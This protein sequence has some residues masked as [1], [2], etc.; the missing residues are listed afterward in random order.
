MTVGNSQIGNSQIGNSQIGHSHVGGTMGASA[1]VPA[2]ATLAADA[3]AARRSG[4]LFHPLVDFFC[5]GGGSLLAL[6]VLALFVPVREAQVTVAVWALAATHAINHP[7]FAHSYQLFYAG[8][9]RKA[10][11]DAFPPGLRRRYLFA[12]VAVP[13]LLAA[14]LAGTVLAGDKRMLGWAGNAMVFFVGWHYAKQGYGMAMLDAVLKRRF[15]AAGEKR[16]L[17]WNAHACWLLAWLLGNDLVS[18][19]NLWGL[20]YYSFAVPGWLLWVAVAAAAASG[21][22]LLAVLLRKGRR[23]GW[24]LPW[25]GLL[26]YGASLYAWLVFVQVNPLFLLVVPAFHSLQYLVVVWRFQINRARAHPLAA[27]RPAERGWLAQLPSLAGLRISFFLL[28]GIGL[29]W[30][31]FWGLPEWLGRSVG[32]D[33]ATFGPTLFLFCCWIFINLHHYFLDSVLWRRENPE[34]KRWLF[35][36]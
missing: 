20:A 25:N 11:G 19:A 13:L 6:A 2:A 32:Y 28:L 29:G 14:W 9:R 1:A 23:E 27:L 10:F 31:G 8:F 5:L 33:R 34:T 7:H 16:L 3:P 26:A 12:G 24:R 21:L 30:L 17:L 36:G 35:G 4:W 15:F 18:V 22:A